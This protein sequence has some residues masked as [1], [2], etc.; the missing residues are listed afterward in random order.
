M[1]NTQLLVGYKEIYGENNYEVSEL[2][3]D[4]P[5]TKVG[6]IISKINLE[7]HIGTDNAEQMKYFAY[8]TSHLSASERG[9]IIECS[10]GVKK[11][12]VSPENIFYFSRHSLLYL[13][14]K[15]LKYSEKQS[16]GIEQDLTNEERDNLF[17][18]ILIANDEV[19]GRSFSGEVDFSNYEEFRKFMWRTANLQNQFDSTDPVIKVIKAK[20]FFDMM[21]NHNKYSS[22]VE[23]LLSAYS[24]D[25]TWTLLYR[26][27][28][29]PYMKSI[30]ILAE[31]SDTIQTIN[32]NTPQRRFYEQ[33][34]IN[35]SEL[36][37]QHFSLKV[38]K[39]TPLL[40]IN[41]DQC[42][43]LD[44]GLY[45][46]Q[47]FEA[48]IFDFF[49]TTRVRE[50]GGFNNFLHYKNELIDSQFYEEYLLKRIA[51]VLFPKKHQIK[52]SE[53]Q[54]R[55]NSI[56]ITP[57][58]YVRDGNNVFLIEYKN[59]YYPSSIDKR[60]DYNEIKCTID[61]RFNS[62]ESGVGQQIKRVNYLIKNR[63][64]DVEEPNYP[65]NRNLNIFPVIIFSDVNYN[66]PGVG[67][68]LDESFKNQIDE[69]T[70]S[71]FKNIMSLVFIHVD[72]FF[73]HID[74][75][76]KKPPLFKDHLKRFLRYQSIQEKK[77]AKSPNNLIIHQE[78]DIP[79]TYRIR[80]LYKYPNNRKDFIKASFEAFDLL[81]NT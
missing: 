69:S 47:L 39:Q 15:V 22:E 6:Q 25:N 21:Q 50:L 45:N 40:K 20:C 5:V 10:L 52:L 81:Q 67:R 53:E 64:E 60:S 55:D 43:V 13:F 3:A 18:A 17:K 48:N 31:S 12:Y 79:F 58:Y 27:R 59:S 19:N 1:I 32:I 44:W 66:I 38:F 54:L 77:L 14:F 23:R 46:E 37:N 28:L 24:A 34:I 80:R 72:Y 11:D 75:F 65:R 7:I 56:E 4:L 36:K 62:E 76:S 71:Q 68:Y 49:N 63:F 57:D 78:L 73:E 30:K 61:E 74:L 2:I 29:L 42:V 70:R 9:R 41:H 35:H 51:D 16:I 33:L 8:F 26:D